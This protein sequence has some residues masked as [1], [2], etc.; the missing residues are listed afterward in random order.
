MG[1]DGPIPW[2]ARSPDL[3]PC[4]FFWWGDMNEKV[5][6]EPPQNINEFKDKIKQAVASV[7]QDTLQKIHVNM[8]FQLSFVVREQRL[9]FEYIF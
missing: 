7:T 1:I 8:K 4:D 6:Q 2:P 3:T 9:Q 5:Y